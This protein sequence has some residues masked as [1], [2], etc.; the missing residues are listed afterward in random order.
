M[1]RERKALRQKAAKAAAPVV[2]PVPAPPK[3]QPPP[4]PP[5]PAVPS[6]DP[7]TELSKKL[8][9]AVKQR[10]DA[11]KALRDKRFKDRRAQQE[12]DAARRSRIL[13]I[14]AK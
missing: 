14:E 11:W 12:R 10:D 3:P 6:A 4:A 1:F 8:V 2:P 5:T 13:S 7:S 9:A